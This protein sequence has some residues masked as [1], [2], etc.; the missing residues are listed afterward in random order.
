MSVQT[1]AGTPPG[2]IRPV[3]IA[4]VPDELSAA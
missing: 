3:V 1:F 2:R 4:I